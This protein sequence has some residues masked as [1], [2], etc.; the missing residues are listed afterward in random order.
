MASR[1][2]KPSGL[3]QP[4]A[5]PKMPAT[6][7]LEPKKEVVPTSTTMAKNVRSNVE[8]KPPPRTLTTRSRT[9]AAAA[10]VTK[11]PPVPTRETLKRPAITSRPQAGVKRARLD[12]PVKPGPSKPA[13][14]AKVESKPEVK[15]NRPKPSK[16]DLKGRVEY[17]TEELALVQNQYHES[18]AELEEAK[19][20]LQEI[21]D[22]EK[23]YK[24]KSEK[25]EVKCENLTQEVEEHRKKTQK[26]EEEL[27]EIQ[28]KKIQFE[29]KYNE[30]ST[31]LLDVQDKYKA[32]EA[33]NAILRNDLASS[34]KE[35]EEKSDALSEANS[36]I[37]QLKSVVYNLDRE[38]RTLHNTIQDL[39][40]KIRVFCRVRPKIDKEMDKRC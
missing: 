20:K 22:N 6:K 16:W 34:R 5:V 31:I 4:K 2:P 10:P 7:V 11:K 36:I 32:G 3:T 9:V 12:A 30:T 14:P 18:L 28:L 1:L 17:V 29:N 21:Q 13:N 27:Q 37:E 26:L 8:N 39:K 23:D 24:D 25:L 38:R 35:N 19:A 40:G 33:A 15:V